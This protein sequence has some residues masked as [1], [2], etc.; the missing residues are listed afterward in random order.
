MPGGSFV[1]TSLTVLL[2]LSFV[3]KVTWMAATY[4]RL[5]RMRTQVEAA[6][7][8]IDVQLRRRHSLLADL[9]EV[10]RRYADD[11]RGALAAV[12]DA[13]LDAV[14]AARRSVAAQ[15]V[16]ER[17]LTQALRRLPALT[18]TYPGLATDDRFRATCDEL[19]GTADKTAYA[20]EYYNRA[21]QALNG[22]LSSA[23]TNVVARLA[24]IAPWPPFE[25]VEVDRRDD[26]VRF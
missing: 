19:A 1:V 10:V 11:G 6:W 21:T 9:L 26:S 18:D 23:P 25:V 12:A 2:I 15:V 4:R 20:L 14:R 24:R 3:L 13:Q 16:A 8:Q 7:T 5:T 22:A 17:R